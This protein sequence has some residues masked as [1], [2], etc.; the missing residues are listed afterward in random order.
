MK[1]LAEI[2][3]P[4]VEA[5]RQAEQQGDPEAQRRANLVLRMIGKRPPT[6]VSGLQFTLV[7]DK[8]WR[9]PVGATP[10]KVN[11]ALHVTN[12]TNKVYRLCF[13]EGIRLVFQ[14]S[15]GKML[16]FRGGRDSSNPPKITSPPLG[17]N[18]C[19]VLLFDSTLRL[20][21]GNLEFHAWDASLWFCEVK[22][23]SKGVYQVGLSYD[24]SRHATDGGHPFW[25]GSVHTQMETVVIK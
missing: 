11:V 9:I 21:G 16:P 1:R 19:H 6:T 18:E 7:T 2:G 22:G 24:N 25:I 5:L 20:A 23:L 8:E 13:Q 17:K 15:T 3:V 12:T 14:D 10:A 4:A